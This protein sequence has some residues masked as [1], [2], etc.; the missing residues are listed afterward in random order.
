[1]SENQTRRSVL[2][3]TPPHKNGSRTSWIQR[4]R[5]AAAYYLRRAAYGRQREPGEEGTLTAAIGIKIRRRDL[6]YLTT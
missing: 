5:T 3:P 1:M 6:G 4:K 2:A